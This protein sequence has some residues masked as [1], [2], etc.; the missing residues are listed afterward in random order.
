MINKFLR[1]EMGARRVLLVFLGVIVCVC[2]VRAEP[3]G[4]T[5]VIAAYQQSYAMNFEVYWM[6]GLPSGWYATFDGYSVAQIAP[7]RWVYGRVKRPGAIVPTEVLV[8]SVV[9]MDVPEL[10]R[11]AVSSWRGGA[12]ETKE[13]RSIAFSG[14]DNMGVLDD[15]LAYTPVAWKTGAA[16]LRIWL[17]NRWYNIDPASGQSTFQALLAK[18]PYI[19][20]SL[21][22]RNAFWTRSD[23]QDLADLAREWGYV[24][25]GTI[26][27]VSLTGRRNDNSSGSE[28]FAAG[29][30]GVIGG[31][32]G[33]S[34]GGQWDVGGG[35]GSSSGGGGGWDTGGSPGGTGGGSGGG[36]DSGG[37]SPGGGSPGEG[38][39]G[40]NDGGGWD[41]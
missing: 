18:H 1:C 31:S 10:A 33:G 17:G 37:S 23:T 30:G 16:E 12:Y 32:G 25:R 15:P 13:F 26:P 20:R 36:W 41:K 27:F 24:W 9:P 39:G 7:N 6:E 34:G 21:R 40:G 3:A 19:V 8:G 35:E 22:K 5:P 2:L 38:S 11:V 14:M 28:G 4:A 29:P